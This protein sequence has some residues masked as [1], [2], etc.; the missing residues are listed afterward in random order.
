MPP[1]V[2]PSCAGT[3][4]NRLAH[5]PV[6]SVLSVLSIPAARSS[7]RTVSIKPMFGLRLT[8]S[9]ETRFLIHGNDA[10]SAGDDALDEG[11]ATESVDS[12]ICDMT[13]SLEFFTFD[14][15][16]KAGHAPPD[17]A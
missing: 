1:F 15:T 16:E 8:V 9:K 3:V 17:K 4:A 7:S 14:N 11:W 13:L 10:G 5:L 2:A 6:G 12:A